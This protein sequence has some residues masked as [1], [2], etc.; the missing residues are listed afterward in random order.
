MNDPRKYL[1]TWIPGVSAGALLAL[2]AGL[3]FGCSPAYLLRAGWEEA[4]ILRSRTEIEEVVRDSAAPDALRNKLRLVRNARD[5][6]E[7]SLGLDAG[8]TFTSYAELE[9][10]TL[11]LLVSAAPRFRLAW[12]TWWFPIVGDVPYRGYFDV[13]AARDE[14]ERLGEQGY[15]TWVRPTSAFSTLGWL[16]DP[17]LSTTLRDD[18]VGIVQTVIHEITHTTWFPSGEAQFNE[19][20][21]N[22]AGHVGAIGFFCG[23][24]EDEAS[25]RTATDRWHD[26]RILGRFFE[27]LVEDLRAHYSR[28]GS[29][30][31]LEAGKRE[32]L[33]TAASR[34]ER[35]V[36]PRLRSG[37]YGGLDPDR[38]NNAW[39]LARLLYFRRLDDFETVR[40][41]YERPEEAI[42]AVLTAAREADRPWEGLDRLLAEP[43]SGRAAVPTL[44]SPAEP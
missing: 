40:R 14:A 29:G 18:S 5:Y 37:R 38:I 20:F 34:F 4:K 26:T 27:G 8:S 28:D 1:R 33:L 2:T 6:A 39:L 31:A 12:K 36:R 13:E 7:R 30:E 25:C 9:S 43:A 21:A 42:D 11:V 23:A 3:V 15:D 44:P 16:P 35:E 32:I 22:F 24:L 41:R 17:V 10:D 19:S